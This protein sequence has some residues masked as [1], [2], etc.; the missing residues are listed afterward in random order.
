MSDSEEE[1]FCYFG[2]PLD[3]YDEDAF[4]KKKPISVEE[5]IA[6]D[7]QGRRR[8]H[9][10][11]T[12]GFSA[13]FYNTVGSLE[14]WIPSEFK[15]SRQEKAKNVA[16][17]PEDFMDEEDIGEHGIAPQ[18]VRATD[19]FSTAK[20]KKKTVSNRLIK[21]LIFPD[22]PIPGDPVLQTLLTSGNETVGYL[23]LKNI[24]IQEKISKQEEELNSPE[25]KIYG[26]Q[27]PT[28]YKVSKN[29]E[30]KQYQIPTIYK[31]FL[32]K[33]KSN[34][35]GLGYEGLDKSHINL[36]QSS[37]LVMKDKNNK[38]VSISGQAFGVGAFEDEDDDI[39]VKEDMSKYDFELTK[40]KASNKQQSDSSSLL[41]GM[42]KHSKVP[43]ILKK[44][45]LTPKIP[46]SFSGKHKVRKS[47]FEPIIEESTP[48]D[49]KEINP[50]IRARYLGENTEKTY[51]TSKPIVESTSE[52]N[53]II[54]KKENEEEHSPKKDFD[55]SS[56]FISDRFVSA[57]QKEDISNI[58]EPVQKTEILHGT[59]EMREAARM[60][61][62][63]LLTRITTD[64]HP[65]AILC[66]RFNVPEP[67]LESDHIGFGLK[68]KTKKRTKNLIF[69]YQKHTEVEGP[70]KPGL[71][72]RSNEE[73]KLVTPNMNLKDTI[74]STE[75][76][77]LTE[78]VMD[79]QQED[80]Q[81][82]PQPVV[83]V[84]ILDLESL[85]KDITEKVNVAEKL[86]LFKAV[87]L[88]SSESEDEEDNSKEG[89][90][91]AH[92]TEEL[93]IN[94]L[95]DHLLPKIK[96]IKE[97]ILSNVNFH[98]FFKPKKNVEETTTNSEDQ[99]PF[100]QSCNDLEE[101]QIDSYGP[102]LP[103]EKMEIK[104]VSKFTV[105]SSNS[106]DEWVEKRKTD[107]RK[108]SKNK[109]KHKK[110]EA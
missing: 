9:G 99:S 88:S 15:S 8:F 39:Y 58:L 18:T 34:T 85:P 92:R 68:K 51:T 43:L 35:F 33:P 5:Q 23:L 32:E 107:K 61:M 67:F 79:S 42:F 60:K 28:Q 81:T 59:V 96:P 89:N 19:D 86:D 105:L 37:S 16:Q 24:G 57:S 70:L 82:N 41:F 71:S 40:E 95:S 90:D 62:F 50:A 47:R 27:M 66:K 22:G 77:T 69:E 26:C 101:A 80:K 78:P 54:G 91:E 104:G 20:K 98:E 106:E 46:H 73:D 100:V 38:K 49:R 44:L 17:K 74:D 52:N 87:F 30:N 55:I 13:G 6:T 64:W 63:G 12:G 48:L 3:P 94:I 25:T 11:F 53:E 4:P 29:V 10:A 65:C 84:N 14:G 21:A 75:S 76:C 45:Y 97:G 109:R 2:K 56:S 93:K 108:K 31:E 110:R 103:I 36:F 1:S 102:R 72:T 7:A 83:E